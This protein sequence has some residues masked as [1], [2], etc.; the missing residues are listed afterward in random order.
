MQSETSTVFCKKKE[1]NTYLEELLVSCTT[2]ENLLDEDFLVG[3]RE[4]HAK[5]EQVS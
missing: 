3:V 5:R 4:L 2:I 1:A